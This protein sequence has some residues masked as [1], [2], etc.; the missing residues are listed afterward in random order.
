[1]VPS[2]AYVIRNLWSPRPFEH[3]EVPASFDPSKPFLRLLVDCRSERLH[4]FRLL[5]NLERVFA[6]VLIAETFSM[7]LSIAV[8]N[9]TR[10]LPTFRAW[11]FC[12]QVVVS[13][14]SAEHF[15]S[16]L[17][18]FT[19]TN[20]VLHVADTTFRTRDWSCTVRCKMHSRDQVRHHFFHFVL[21]SNSVLFASY[22]GRAPLL[23]FGFPLP[24]LVRLSTTWAALQRK[25]EDIS[26]TD[27]LCQK[28][29][30]SSSMV[31]DIL[32]RSPAFV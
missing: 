7:L 14:A 21:F 10:E 5:R 16:R 24:P 13:C 27:T 32:N 28:S 4:C 8:K 2:V 26:L 20:R 31:A 17:R 23:L 1:M 19:V 25:L 22:R 15:L 9:Q 30:H 29:C 11:L 18:C 12:Y 3:W 6:L